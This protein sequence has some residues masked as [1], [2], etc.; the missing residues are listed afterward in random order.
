MPT[1]EIPGYFYF[2]MGIVSVYPW[3][4]FLNLSSFF[5]KSFN[6]SKIIQQYTFSYYLF[7]IVA[8]ILTLYF[9]KRIRLMT[10]VKISFFGMVTCFNIIYPVCM[11]QNNSKFKYICF[12]ASVVVLSTCHFIFEVSQLEFDIWPDLR[13]EEQIKSV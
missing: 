8:I 3:N 11:M 10:F 12:H 13:A 1:K 9:E 4:S 7:T 6:S 2:L 5:E